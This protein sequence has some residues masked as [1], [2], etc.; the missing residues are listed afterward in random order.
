MGIKDIAQGTPTSASQIPFYDPTNGVDRRASLA[1]I[2][3]EV[4]SINGSATNGFERQGY[5]PA[6]TGWSV[7]VAPD[8]S[9]ASVHMLITPVAGYAAGTIVLPAVATVIDGQEV[10]V[11]CTQSVTTLTVSANGAT[12]VNGAPTTLAAN[13]F[14]RLRFDEIN[15]SWY[16]VG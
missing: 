1:T 14:F 12:A 6:A 8:V 4:A 11:T 13:A 3:A 7:T 10:L 5:S 16:R 2:A 9:G 15:D